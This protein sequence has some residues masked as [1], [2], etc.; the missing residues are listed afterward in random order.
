MNYAAVG[1]GFASAI[2][3]LV[4]AWF[5]FRH[6]KDSKMTIVLFGL[7]GMIGAG[8]LWAGISAAVRNAEVGLAH[9]LGG[10]AGGGAAGFLAG[11][12]I[13]LS[14]EV[15]W[16]ALHRS[17]QPKKWHPWASL[18]LGIIITSSGIGVFTGFSDA[19]NSVTTQ[20][21]QDTLGSGR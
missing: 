21:G 4:A 13:I 14:L 5:Y 6:K 18:A 8:G 3:S 15:F 9:G 10:A 16:K 1:A 11:I 12:P 20:I 17:G 7:A 2:L 19:I